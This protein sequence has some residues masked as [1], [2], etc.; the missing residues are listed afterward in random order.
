MFSVR[1]P[2]GWAGDTTRAARWGANVVFR[3]KGSDP[4]DTQGTVVR[5]LVTDKTDENT[6]EDLRGDMESYK[7]RYPN[8]L[9]EDV[10]ATHPSYRSFSKLF[11]VPAQF[12]EYVA[13]LNPGP[14]SRHLL[15]VSLSKKDQKA[16]AQELAAYRAVIR[17]LVLLAPREGPTPTP[18]P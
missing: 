14:G 4:N 9:F 13:Y 16:D 6:A 7:E 15:S 18:R 1:E 10:E 2:E 5:V 17:S 8:I 11:H 3:R 12:S